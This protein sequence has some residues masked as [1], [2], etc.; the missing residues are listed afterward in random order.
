MNAL[1]SIVQALPSSGIRKIFDRAL[2]LEK[3][4][5][6][7]LRFDIG[8]PDIAT[9]QFIIDAAKVALDGGFTQYVANRGIPDLLDAIAGKLQ[10][11]NG[12]RYDPETEI[13][14][15]TGASEAV[16]AALFAVL[17]AGTEVMVPEPIWPHYRSCAQLAGATVVPV[18]LDIDNQFALE[19]DDLERH[20]SPR[21][22]LL[23]LS[24]PVNPTGKVYGRQ[25]LCQVLDFA[26]RHNLLVLA[27]EIYEH[28]VFDEPFCSFASLPGAR[29]RTIL[30]NGFSKVFGMTGWRL[31]YVAAPAAVLT[32]I[33]KV[34]Q[35]MTV[36]ATSFAQKGAVQAYSHPAAGPFIQKVVNDYRKKNRVLVEEAS[37]VPG[38]TCCP[39]GGAFYFFPRLPDGL[40]N[41]E[42]MAMI[43]LDQARVAVVPGNVFGQGYERYLR[44]SYG[45]CSVPELREGMRRISTLFQARRK[46]A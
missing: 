12:V 45:T 20:V 31:G 18:P 22:R 26:Q 44:I 40:P 42:E 8:R 41:A 35:Y 38:L 27:D 39:P 6:R 29:E 37:R 36:C 4:G 1:S 43:L 33:N 28:F 32:Q 5:H 3:E 10:R 19:L 15:T 17:E 25:T 34:H 23:V 14:V 30:V 21:T 2:A 16:A 13:V 11:E 7:V 9:P 46:A 24:N